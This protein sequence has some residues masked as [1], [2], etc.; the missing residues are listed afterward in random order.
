MHKSMKYVV[1]V[2]ALSQMAIQTADVV[3]GKEM[4]VIEGATHFFVSDGGEE[5]GVCIQGY[6]ADEKGKGSDLLGEFF[7][8]GSYN[9]NKEVID[10]MSLECLDPKAQL[11]II[12]KAIIYNRINGHG[13]QVSFYAEDDTLIDTSLKYEGPLDLQGDQDN[14]DLIKPSHLLDNLKEVKEETPNPEQFWLESVFA[15]PSP[16]TTKSIKY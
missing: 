7:I 6:C 1:C 10:K 13:R 4:D 3:L 8:K 12:T 16:P 5:V 15:K 11:P 14:P 9:K 2:I